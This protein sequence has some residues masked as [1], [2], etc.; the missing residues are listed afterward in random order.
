M[1]QERNSL[2]PCAIAEN[3]LLQVNTAG[4]NDPETRSQLEENGHYLE[5]LQAMSELQRAIITQLVPLAPRAMHSAIL[6]EAVA[7]FLKAQDKKEQRHE[8]E[9][10]VA[11]LV[12]DGLVRYFCCIIDSYTINPRHM[13]IARY[14]PDQNTPYE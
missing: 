10:A 7:P 1:G 2:K 4:G 3:T 13:G 5:K 11:P 6:R 8:F 14:L 9:A 12:Q